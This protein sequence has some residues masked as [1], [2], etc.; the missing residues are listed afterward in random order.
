MCQADHPFGPFTVEPVAHTS[1][2][3]DSVASAPKVVMQVVE[4]DVGALTLPGLIRDR[5]VGTLAPSFSMNLLFSGSAAL[6]ALR[7][8]LEC[9]VVVADGV[10]IGVHRPGTAPDPAVCGS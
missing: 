5:M 7:A 4:L 9:V 8:N 1:L 2:T 10:R 6:Q 3:L